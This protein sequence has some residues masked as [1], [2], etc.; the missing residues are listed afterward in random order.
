MSDS[1]KVTRTTQAQS[2]W[3]LPIVL[4]STLAVC[5]FIMY[6]N[7]TLWMTSAQAENQT[8]CAPVGDR[9]CCDPLLTGDAEK[10][11]GTG[12]QG[13]DTTPD[14]SD[15][16]SRNVTSSAVLDEARSANIALAVEAIDEITIAPG[17]VFSFNDIIGNTAEDERYQLAPVVADDTITLAKG[18][19]ICQLATALYITALES[20][21]DIVE[22]HPHTVVVD[23]APLGLDATIDYEAGVDLKFKNTSDAPIMIRAW[24]SDQ[25]VTVEFRGQ[26][27]PSGIVIKASSNI[28][29]VVDAN[30]NRF[31]LDGS[32]IP[33]SSEVL[34]IVDSSRTFFQDGD[35]IKTE[36]IGHDIYQVDGIR[37]QTILGGIR[38]PLK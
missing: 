31:S 6:G 22:R 21:M 8:R 17:A 38:T 4:L 11:D 1:P 35:K 15:V 36:H 9:S 24:S 14:P 13:S 7:P 3:V 34:L 19:G 30:G 33:A 27:L 32:D 28:A 5:A 18:G 2:P 10:P 16:I 25:T 26:A 23:Y 29:D 12:T 20:D 37:I